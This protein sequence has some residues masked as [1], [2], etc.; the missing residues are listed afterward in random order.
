MSLT[1]REIRNELEKIYEERKSW[2]GAKGPFTESAIRR[3]KLILMRQQTLYQLENAKLTKNEFEESFY[4]EIYKV[5]NNYLKEF[6]EK[7]EQENEIS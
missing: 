5:I 7:T 3:K 6:S 4:S 1:I 2:N